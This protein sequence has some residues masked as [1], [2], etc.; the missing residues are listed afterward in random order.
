MKNNDFISF[1]LIELM[2]NIKSAAIAG[3]D[4]KAHAF[5]DEL[6]VLALRKIAFDECDPKAAAEY[7][8]TSRS[9]KFSR[10]CA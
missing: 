7:V 2:S 8:L 3:D 5:E 9:I 6:F 1:D 10:W 4:E